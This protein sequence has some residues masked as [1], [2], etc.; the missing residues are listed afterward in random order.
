MSA[1][2]PWTGNAVII[3]VVIDFDTLARFAATRS[4]K[5]LAMWCARNRITT[6]R[7]HKGRPCTTLTALDRALV[8]R[9]KN[10]AE[11]DY[12]AISS[13]PRSSR[14]QKD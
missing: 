4:P 7:D 9:R 5:A 6:F 1:P 13:P 12:D 10:E 8:P 2:E 14:P 3:A 11:P